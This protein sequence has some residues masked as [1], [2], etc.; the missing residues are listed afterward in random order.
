MTTAE[1]QSMTGKELIELVTGTQPSEEAIAWVAALLSDDAVLEG[2]RELR[3]RFKDPA[4]DEIPRTE[5]GRIASSTTV[6]IDPDRF[7][8]FSELRSLVDAF[9]ELYRPMVLV[10]ATA[11]LR[12]AEAFGLTAT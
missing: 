10:M 2:A 8:A 11:G 5:S 9:P 7:R 6:Q 3:A 12:R 4:Y 1:L